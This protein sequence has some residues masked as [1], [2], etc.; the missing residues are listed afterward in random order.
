M[1]E[2]INQKEFTPHIL[3]LFEDLIL[4]NI[5]SGDENIRALAVRALNLICIL[6]IEIAKRYV[7]DLL[8]II[9]IDKKHV[10]IEAFVALTDSITVYSLNRLTS[11][12][13][14]QETN[15]TNDSKGILKVMSKQMDN[16]DSEIT[17]IAVE[18]FC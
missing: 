6:N 14:N 17:T 15:Q 10:A 8:K 9:Q 12:D 3:S 2:N 1:Q 13:D 16:D 5:N 18:G 11:L 4:T 7:P